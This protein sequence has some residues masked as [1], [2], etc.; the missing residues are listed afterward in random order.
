VHARAQLA[1]GN[2]APDPVSVVDL[3]AG[4]MLPGLILV[5][6]YLGY[7]GWVAWRE[8]AR[9]PPMPRRDPVPVSTLIL[10]LGAPT[11]L[12]LL[13]LGSILL[14]Y[15]TPTESAG[16]GAVGALGLAVGRRRLSLAA[17][18]SVAEQ[19]LQMT[20]MIFVILIG[21]SVFSLVFI[22]LDGESIVRDILANLPGGANA[23][24]A[25]VMVLVFLL[26]FPLDFLEICVIVVP[27]V[28]P[29]LLMM[30][31]D[32]L[33][34]GVLLALNLQ[35]SFL[36]PPVGPT[37]FYLRGV[38][39]PEVPTLAIYRGV[40]PFVFLQVLGLALVWLFPALATWLPATA[41][42]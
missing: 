21:A 20:A 22:G 7:Q 18:R 38:A 30:G 4:A 35:T 23:A 24:L 2:Y 39:P 36:T 32:P 16:V 8:P 12:I 14:G 1:M 19:T 10:A 26:G 33:W 42:N 29:A 25:V 9:C 6:L 15:A 41:L 3:F 28:G 40:I 31:I 37:L 27:I 17:L 5:S 11:L 13:V 34:F